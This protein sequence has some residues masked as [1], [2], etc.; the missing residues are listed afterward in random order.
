MIEFKV[1]ILGAGQIAGKIAAP[2]SLASA[3]I[4]TGV[5]VKELHDG[6]KNHSKLDIVSGALNLALGVSNAAS[7]LGGGIPALVAT[8]VIIVG[9]IALAAVK[10]HLAH[11]QAGNAGN[12]PPAP[13]QPS[14][15]PNPPLP[16]AS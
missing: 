1:G 6:V 10:S 8:G 13:P 5:G 2:F 14:S 12:N 7:A 9:K 15:D 4:S 16:P 3:V 11:H